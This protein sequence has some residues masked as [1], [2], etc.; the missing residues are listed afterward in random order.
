[1]LHLLHTT[2]LQ[3]R[4]YFISEGVIV[5]LFNGTID[6]KYI[7]SLV[8]LYFS[9]HMILNAC[10]SAC[11]HMLGY[12]GFSPLHRLHQNRRITRAFS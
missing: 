12:A 3:D 6:G 4:H 2:K 7:S 10:I 11:I 5:R 9:V 8:V 1:M